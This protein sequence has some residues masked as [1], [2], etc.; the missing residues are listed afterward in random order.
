M[1]ITQ[2]QSNV[3][4]DLDH[5]NLYF[6]NT[7]KTFA[8][9]SESDTISQDCDIYQMSAQSGC[10]KRCL[11]GNPV[12]ERWPIINET[13]ITIGEDQIFDNDSRLVVFNIDACDSHQPE[14]ICTNKNL[15]SKFYVNENG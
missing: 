15:V 2:F 12:T 5:N 9:K 1:L 10:D 13:S 11:C 4:F 7:N 8:W 6:N 14:R 3:I